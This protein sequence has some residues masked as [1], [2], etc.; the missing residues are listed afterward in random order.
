M[1][2]AN[3]SSTGAAADGCTEL[4][5]EKLTGHEAVN[6]RLVPDTAPSAPHEKLTGHEAVDDRLVPD[7]APSAPLLAPTTGDEGDETAVAPVAAL[8]TDSLGGALA[9]LIAAQPPLPE[10]IAPASAAPS[11]APVPEAQPTAEAP[12]M[13]ASS[14]GAAVGASIQFAAPV[15]HANAHPGAPFQFAA[16]VLVS[17]SASLS[18]SSASLAPSAVPSSQSTTDAP[19]LGRS[20]SDAPIL[21]RSTSEDP[22]RNPNDPRCASAAARSRASFCAAPTA[23][24]FTAPSIHSPSRRPLASAAR[25]RLV[26]C[27][28]GKRS[29]VLASHLS[30]PRSV[31]ATSPAPARPPQRWRQL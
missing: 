18:P 8:M 27:R 1:V 26:C 6:D 14:M 23:L 5:D 11:W 12:P 30:V 20:P 19:I 16:P 3:L 15:Q 29:V 25:W 10:A 28:L 4:A 17:S 13:P 2:A 21:G 9:A 7:T 31:P 22:R 24:G